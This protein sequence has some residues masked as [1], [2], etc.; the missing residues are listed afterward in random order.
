MGLVV[1]VCS[2]CFSGRV[3]AVVVTW[4]PWLGSLSVSSVSYQGAVAPVPSV[5]SVCYQGALARVTQCL[6]C[7]LPGSLGSCHPVLVVFVTSEQ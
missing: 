6:Q 7:L 4:E 2:I 3:L 5:F 1:S